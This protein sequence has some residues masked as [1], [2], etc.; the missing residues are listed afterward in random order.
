MPTIED[1]IIMINYWKKSGLIDYKELVEQ[2]E[3]NLEEGLGKLDDEPIIIDR[4]AF[5]KQFIQPKLKVLQKEI[6][7]FLINKIFKLNF[8]P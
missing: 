1:A 3:V 2:V 5:F 4:Q 6:I 8:T 7:E